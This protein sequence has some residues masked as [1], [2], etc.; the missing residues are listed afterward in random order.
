MLSS[1]QI[2]YSVFSIEHNYT[3][4]SLPPFQ[5]NHLLYT[6]RVIKLLISTFILDFIHV[7]LQAHSMTHKQRDDACFNLHDIHLNI[8]LFFN[9]EQVCNF[10]LRFK[11]L[12]VEQ[13]NLL[14]FYNQHL[15][16]ELEY[17]TYSPLFFCV[18]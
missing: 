17:Y 11:R 2:C 15:F 12:L 6:P 16:I 13:R 10:Q 9:I 18:S 5:L 7:H 4:N 1:I 14:Y 3:P 8:I